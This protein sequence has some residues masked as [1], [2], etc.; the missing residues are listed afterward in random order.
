MCRGRVNE[1]GRGSNERACRTGRSL[2]EPQDPPK[3]GACMCEAEDCCAAFLQGYPEIHMS[4]ATTEPFK[5]P[6]MK[7]IPPKAVLRSYACSC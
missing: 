7:G 1:L 2:R 4:S 5:R 6:C 3:D